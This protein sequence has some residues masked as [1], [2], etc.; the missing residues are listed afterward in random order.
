MSSPDSTYEMQ[1]AYKRFDDYLNTNPV[2]PD[3]NR[4]RGSLADV[5][6]EPDPD[7]I[8]MSFLEKPTP[9]PPRVRFPEVDVQTKVEPNVTPRGFSR[10]YSMMSEKELTTI[11]ESDDNVEFEKL[12]SHIAK[13][14][15][16]TK[17]PLICKDAVA[18]D[19]S[20]D[21]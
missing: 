18:L 10:R 16:P 2:M 19:I 4:R 17:L 11:L 12:M 6:L 8:D 3:R 21:I 15:Q 7:D 1:V 14:T 9:E 13:K 20:N 5:D